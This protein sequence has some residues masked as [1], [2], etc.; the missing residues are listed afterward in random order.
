MPCSGWFVKA[1]GCVGYGGEGLVQVGAEP[2][3][4]GCEEDFVAVWDYG[5]RS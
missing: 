3:T 4:E 1:D 5:V 2:G